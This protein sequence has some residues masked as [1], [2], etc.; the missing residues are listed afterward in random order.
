MPKKRFNATSIFI[1]ALTIFTVAFFAG[2]KNGEAAE[3]VKKHAPDTEAL[4]SIVEHNA[5]IKR[6][7]I[8]SIEQARRINP[9]KETNPAQTLEEY[10][11][12][13]DWAATAMPF[14]ILPAAERYPKVYESIDQSL[15][16]FYFLIDQPLD[17]LRGKGYYY[18]SLQYVEPFRSW[19][20][21]F[22]KHWGEYLS[23]KASWNEEL[24]KKVCAD[25]RFGMNKGWYESPEKWSTF[26]EFFARRL[27]S[28][29]V[30]PIA[31]AMNEA[32]VVSPADSTPQGV[33]KI[34]R[35]S[36]IVQQQGVRLKS[37]NF[38]SVA[39]I[40][41]R[42]SA[43]AGEF[44]NG[45]LTHTFLD[46]NDYH[47]YH[48][49]VSGT[50]KEVRT[51]LA[52][53]AAGGITVWNEKLRKY[54]LEDQ[55]PGWQSIETRACVVIDTDNYGLVAVLPIGMSQVS[56]V[57]FEENVRVGAKV[58]KGDPLGYFL[59]G[60]SD[61]VMIFQPQAGFEFTAPALD[62]DSYKHIYMGEAYGIMR[63]VK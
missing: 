14:N 41:G 47:R 50:V 61:I 57:N 37:A 10:Y 44:A 43:Y 36:R 42:D 19:M 9:D 4:I 16:Y 48:F 12:Y 34:D 29:A 38:N 17:E 53:D 56:S 46:V 54:V 20:I 31:A 63:G 62:A 52:D 28:P 51:I 7:L 6:M 11:D 40:L 24:Y 21:I 32:V 23:T 27:S 55:I 25:E 22:T 60:G 8:Q 2:I 26:N 18:N 5:D 13:I 15:D 30:R 58:K 35:N 33:W 3:T 45:V 49:P 1:V 39:D 59:F